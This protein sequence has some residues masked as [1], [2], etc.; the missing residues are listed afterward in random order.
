MQL[1]VKAFW[2]YLILR[3]IPVDT[4]REKEDLVD[5]VLCHQG[6]SSED[7]L[8]MSSLNSSRSQTSSFFTY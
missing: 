7:N 5:L 4:C 3:S 1:N 8:D 2:Q 6:L